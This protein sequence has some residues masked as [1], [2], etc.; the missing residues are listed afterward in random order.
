M[1]IPWALVVQGMAIS[2]AMTLALELTYALLWGVR[3][4]RGFLILLLG[5]LLTNPVVVLDR[6]ST[7]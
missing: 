4:R 1:N 5:N 2:L 3:G 7:V 6:K